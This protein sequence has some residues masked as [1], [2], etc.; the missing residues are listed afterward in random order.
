[1]TPGE[2]SVKEN[3]VRL[4]AGSRFLLRLV[5]GGLAY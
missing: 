3:K 5:E 1:L 2:Y 4:S